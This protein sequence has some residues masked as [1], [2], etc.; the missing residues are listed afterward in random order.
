[1]RHVGQ[2][3]NQRLVQ[4]H[5]DCRTVLES[6]SIPLQ[7]RSANYP[8]TIRLYALN[9]NIVEVMSESIMGCA[10][11][12]EYINLIFVTS[13]TF[14]AEQ[15]SHLPISGRANLCWNRS[16]FTHMYQYPHHN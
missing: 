2:S 7:S 6:Q 14:F 10:S 4:I 15:S 5:T 9:E 13:Y 12:E 3:T 1:M 11:V 16:A 8:E